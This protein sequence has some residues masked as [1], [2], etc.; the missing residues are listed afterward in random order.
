[1][2]IST[3][4]TKIM[5]LQSKEHVRSKICIENTIFEQVSNINYLEYNLTHKGEIDI[6]NKL[7]K[8]NRELRIINKLFHPAKVRR[9]TRLRH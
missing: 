2:E 5:A 3:T 4:K 9:H 7:E 6:E 1:M 8:F